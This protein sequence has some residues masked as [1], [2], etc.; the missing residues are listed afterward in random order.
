MAQV[1]RSQVEGDVRLWRIRGELELLY[2]HLRERNWEKARRI[3]LIIR[4][5]VDAMIDE[6]LQCTVP[7]SDQ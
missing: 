7:M 5:E 3:L 1:S 6:G 2:M 4:D